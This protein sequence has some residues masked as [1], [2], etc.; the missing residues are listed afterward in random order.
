MASPSIPPFPFD[1]YQRY[2]FGTSVF[3]SWLGE[4]AR[5]CGYFA[6]QSTEPSNKPAKTKWTVRKAAKKRSKE[7]P[8]SLLTLTELPLLAEIV[9]N[10]D[11]EI[12][13]SVVVVLKQVIKARTQCARFYTRQ[14]GDQNPKGPDAS[15]EYAIEIFKRVLDILT[16]S[17]DGGEANG[18]KTP[19]IVDESGHKVPIDFTNSFEGL[20]IEDPASDLE[21]YAANVQSINAKTKKKQKSGVRSYEMEDPLAD[22]MMEIFFFFSDL[23]EVRS[24][25]QQLWRDYQDGKVDL[26]VRLSSL[27]CCM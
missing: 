13:L 4:A 20:K 27:F 9:A 17:A 21:D 5:K 15:H 11:T 7:T 18:K 6:Q 8:A 10:S 16:P 23:N 1:T 26:S 3:V 24:Y 19:I 14:N 2:K 22:Y 25:L 12:P